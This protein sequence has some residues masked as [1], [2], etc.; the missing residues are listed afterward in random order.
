MYVEQSSDGYEKRLYHP[1]DRDR[2]ALERTLKLCARNRNVFRPG[3]LVEHHYDFGSTTI[4]DLSL[5]GP[6]PI[7]LSS[8]S[9]VLLANNEA[10]KFACEQ[11]GQPATCVCVEC[12]NPVFLC[13]ACLRRHVRGHTPHGVV[14]SPRMGIC[15]YE[16]P[17]AP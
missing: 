17:G 3:A 13:R 4:L 12:D 15:G 9:V 14:N 6:L 10:P 8:R 1:I 7:A 2:A 5:A 16:G 11:C